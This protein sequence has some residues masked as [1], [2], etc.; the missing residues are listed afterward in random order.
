MKKMITRLK[1]KPFNKTQTHENIITV[2]EL[3]WNS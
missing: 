3:A 1:I 2:K